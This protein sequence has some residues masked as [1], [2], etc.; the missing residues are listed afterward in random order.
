MEVP[1]PLIYLYS[2]AY[3]NQSDA[4]R[5][6]DVAVAVAFVG[7]RAH[8]AGGLFV[9]QLDADRAVR[10]SAEKIEHVAGI[11]TDGDGVALVFLLDVFFCFA[12]LWAR[13]GN[14]NAFFGDG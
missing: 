10:R 5:H 13:S 11:E 7:E 2:N 8:L 3:V 6:D 9:L 14:F 12:V 1:I 4:H